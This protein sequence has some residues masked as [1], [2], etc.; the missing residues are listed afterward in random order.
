MA[1][2]L[3]TQMAVVT[4]VGMWVGSELDRWLDTSPSFTLLLTAAGFA[5]GI[6]RVHL[7]LQQ[8]QDDDDH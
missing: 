1:A 7:G 5:G 2:A 4:A 3:I 8:L 6:Y